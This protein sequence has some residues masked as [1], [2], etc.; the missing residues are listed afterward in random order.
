VAENPSF[1]LISALQ[2]NSLTLFCQQSTHVAA[3][4]QTA[5]SGCNGYCNPSTDTVLDQITSAGGRTYCDYSSY[6]SL[7]N[8]SLPTDVV[9]ILS[10]GCTYL[11]IGEVGALGQAA[12]SSTAAAAQAIVNQQICVADN[13]PGVLGSVIWNLINPGTGPYWGFYTA[14]GTPMNAG[15]YGGTCLFPPQPTAQQWK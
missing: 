8:D 2:F 10:R 4:C 9:N 15:A 13:E 6:D 14:T 5:T 12:D 11:I 7:N 3:T 1:N